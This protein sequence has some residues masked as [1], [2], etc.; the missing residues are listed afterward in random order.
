M[1]HSLLDTDL[2]KLTMWQ[3]ALHQFP[4]ITVKYEFKCRNHA[5]WTPALVDEIAH[6]IAK[7]C[8]LR[9]SSDEL[10]Y[11]RS[12]SFFKEGFLSFL[13][14][15]KP[16]P[17][18][19]RIALEGGEMRIDVEG[20]WFLTIPFEVPVLAIVNEVYFRNRTS[21]NQSA[22]E[23]L[24]RKKEALKQASGFTLVDFGT[25]RRFSMEWHEKVVS[26]LKELPVFAGTSNVELARKFK[27]RPIGTMAHEFMMVGQ[28]RNDVPLVRSQH[29]M[30]QAW[31]DEYRG[32]LGIAL[33]DTLGIDA[34]LRDFDLYFAK[35]YDG[36]RHD[37]GDPLWWAEK[38]LK[39]YESLGI[40]PRT[41]T[42]VFSDG[43]SP[44]KA[45][46]IAE[47]L[48]G[49]AK[50]SFGIGT[51]LTNDMEGVEPLQIVMKIVEANGKPV[52]KVS[53][54]P[55]KGMCKDEAFLDYLRKVFQ[56]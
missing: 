56:I 21:L 36:L 54:S 37:S 27:L 44:T 26:E 45:L 12:F 51:N 43:L 16:N 13:S 32:D 25:R 10:D 38:V 20:P 8:E 5:D 15:Y 30:L 3:A 23:R 47:A 2:Y 14:L 7:F 24:H 50:L 49:R 29:S 17:E 41:K 19:I 33:T 55:G 42:L 39:H 31:V 48:K 1:I 53:D 46:E 11:L 6:E 18:H 35:L 4:T 52:A 9:F 22:Q 34:F 28:A 40:D